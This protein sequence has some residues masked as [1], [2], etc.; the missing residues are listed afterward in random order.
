MAKRTLIL[1]RHAKSSWESDVDDMHRPLSNRGRRDAEAAG[2]ELVERGLTVDVALVS[3][4]ARARETWEGV[5]AGGVTAGEER[6][7]DAV[8]HRTADDIVAAIREVDG[9]ARTVIVIGHSPTIPEAVDLVA[10]RGP[11]K[12]WFAL[13]TKY[14]TSGTAIVELDAEW[15][16][17][18][19][20]LGSL[21]AFRV[22]RA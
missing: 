6:T 13:D 9:R 4:A 8:Y 11:T 17:V 21:V 10:E 20:E 5:K 12:D 19:D 1:M 15:A 22:P 3:P 7:A 18:G 16:D 2:R 14:P